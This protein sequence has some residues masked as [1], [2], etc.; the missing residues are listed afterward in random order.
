MEHDLTTNTN[1]LTESARGH[2][3]PWT[4]LLAQGGGA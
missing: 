3:G 2:C 1:E 4:L